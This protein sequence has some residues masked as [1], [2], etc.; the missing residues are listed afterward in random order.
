M[1]ARSDGVFADSGCVSQGGQYVYQYRTCIHA[2]RIITTSG[3]CNT[4][5]EL[6]WNR[7]HLRRLVIVEALRM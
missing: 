6:L 1:A 5:L 7:L 4:N 2:A 3:T